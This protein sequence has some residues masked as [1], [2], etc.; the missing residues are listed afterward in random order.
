[1][2]AGSREAFV[3]T[4][5]VDAPLERVWQAW[6]D[7]ERLKQWWGPKGFKVHTC[8]LELRPGGMFHYGLRAPDGSDVWGRF[9]YREIVSGQRLNFIVSFSDEKAGVTRHPW[10][11]NWPLHTLSTVSLEA[12]AGKTKITVRWSPHAATEAERKTFEEGRPSMQQGW[13]GTFD[14][15]AAYLAKG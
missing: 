9:V 12:Q 13:T 4:R 2:S 11:P 3:I 6:T 14:Q 1:M 10:S 5:I 7:A 8:K 15:L